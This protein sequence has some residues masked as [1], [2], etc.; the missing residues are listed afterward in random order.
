MWLKQQEFISLSSRVKNIQGQGASQIGFILRP[1]LLACRGVRGGILKKLKHWRTDAFKLWCTTKFLRVPWT[2][3]RSN[4]STLKEINPE[5]SM[6]GLMLKL[7]LQY[8]GHLIWRAGSLEKILMP[9]KIED[10]RRTGD[11][12][13]DGWVTSPMQETWT[14]TNFRRGTGRPGVL[15]SM[16]LQRLG[17]D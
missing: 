14:W 2:A 6:E 15:Q 16:E 9:G 13:W 4:Q 12:G 17:H 7:K 10:R 8:F 1:F 11:R 3:R 5:Y